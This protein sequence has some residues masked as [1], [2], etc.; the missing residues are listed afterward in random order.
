MTLSKQ[1]RIDALRWAIVKTGEIV[2]DG[3]TS[4]FFECT[5]PSFGDVPETTWGELEDMGILKRRPEIG[6]RRYQ[7][8]PYGWIQI[9]ERSGQ[10]REDETLRRAGRLAAALKSFV[11][12]RQA[13]G[14]R[15]GIFL[16]AG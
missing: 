2:R 16:F 12:G 15:P 9:L 5:T 7:V 14:V 11:E 3:Y 1:K 10:L 4:K 6:A 8:T 13:S